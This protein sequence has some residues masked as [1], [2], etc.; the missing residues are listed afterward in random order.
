MPMYD[1]ICRNCESKFEIQQQMSDK[2]LIKC[3]KCS[4]RALERQISNGCGIIFK[5]SG[6]YQTDYKNKK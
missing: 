6:F 1:Y 4:K 3:P 2:K 5:G